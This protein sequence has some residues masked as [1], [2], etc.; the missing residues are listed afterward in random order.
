MLAGFF[1]WNLDV[2][3][4][5]QINL[6]LAICC[7]YFR[8]LA[9]LIMCQKHVWW[10]SNLKSTSINKLSYSCVYLELKTLFHSRCCQES[11]AT[12][13]DFLEQCQSWDASTKAVRLASHQEKLRWS[14]RGS[15]QGQVP[16]YHSEGSYSKYTGCRGDCFLV[17]CWRGYRKK[18]FDWLQCLKNFQDVLIVSM[19]LNWVCRKAFW[20][21][22]V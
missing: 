4:S 2:D 9:V 14:E 18:E 3:T 22:F 13:G 12:C 20:C 19:F 16:W 10:L 15:T 11:P 7:F 6:S 1:I 21:M 5:L 17:L 8:C